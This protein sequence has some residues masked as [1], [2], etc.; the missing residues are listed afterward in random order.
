MFRKY[1]HTCC[2]PTAF[3]IPPMN[4]NK[5]WMSLFNKITKIL[6][7]I[8]GYCYPDTKK[9]QIYCVSTKNGC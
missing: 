2:S 4:M 5:K 1:T 7:I 8:T 3:G 9:L 6:F